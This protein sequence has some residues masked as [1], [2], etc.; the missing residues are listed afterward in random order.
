MDMA[1]VLDLQ[2]QGPDTPE[3]DKRSNSS[4]VLC[5][6]TNQSNKSWAFC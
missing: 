2:E 4:W 3:E 6:G 5:G 1:D